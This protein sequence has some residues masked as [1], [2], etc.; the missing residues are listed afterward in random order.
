MTGIDIDYL[1]TW[2]GN[3]A[4]EE[5]MA[6]PLLVKRFRATFGDHLYDTGSAA[7]LGLHWCLALPIVETSALAPDGHIPKGGFLPPVPLPRRMWAGGDVSFHAPLPVG[8]PIRRLSEITD[9]AQKTGRSGVLV[10]VAVR[11]D[12]FSGDELLISETHNIVYREAGAAGQP[13]DLLEVEEA[14]PGFISADP[15]LLF[16][17]SALTFNSHRIH[18]DLRYVREQILSRP[19]GAWP[20]PGDFADES[21]GETARIDRISFQVSRSLPAFCRSA[22]HSRAGGRREIRILQKH[23]WK[24]DYGSTVQSPVSS[25]S[26]GVMKYL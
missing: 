8:V 3:R 15:A 24:Q 11:H 22:F 23:Q 10:F 20:A 14:P 12:Y 6:T 13:A 25:W 5:D 7:P 1:K 19:G 4:G 9:V 26:H 17:Y 16:R 21:G 2:I 18:Y